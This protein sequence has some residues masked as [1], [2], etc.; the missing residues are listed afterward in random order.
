[1]DDI[2]ICIPNS[3]G[4]IVI[5]MFFGVCVFC[6]KKHEESCYLFHE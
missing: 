2:Y 6:N 5:I 1:M 3:Y 4:G